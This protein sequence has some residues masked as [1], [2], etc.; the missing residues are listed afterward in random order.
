M[1]ICLYIKE[2]RNIFTYTYIHIYT[3][4][5]KDIYICIY[6]YIYLCIMHMHIYLHV[7]IRKCICRRVCCETKQTSLCATQQPDAK[8]LFCVARG[9]SKPPPSCH[10][11]PWYHTYKMYTT[12]SSGIV[13]LEGGAMPS[14]S[15]DT[16]PRFS[17]ANRAPDPK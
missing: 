1:Y 16:K 6:I 3:H 17:V 9:G 13:S 8:R 2:Q 7:R 15:C 5:Y 12:P 14:P 11:R 10:T 4:T